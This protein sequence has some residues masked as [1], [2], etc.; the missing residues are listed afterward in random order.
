MKCVG[1]HDKK[2]RICQ[3]CRDTN[4]HEYQKCID[5]KKYTDRLHD[6][7]QWLRSNC[8]NSYET[9]GRSDEGCPTYILCKI[10]D[11][12][13]CQPTTKCIIKYYQKNV[14]PACISKRITEEKLNNPHHICPHYTKRDLICFEP[15]D[16][17]K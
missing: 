9:I 13:I 1:E 2:D 4:F 3:L 7:K 11:K 6:V 5:R 16:G 12:D 8:P 14:Q 17:L 10:S 15:K